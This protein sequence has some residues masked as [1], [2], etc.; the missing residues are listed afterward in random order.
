MCDRQGEAIPDQWKRKRG[1][2][3]PQES[4]GDYM[5]EATRQGFKHRGELGVCS[6]LNEAG[7]MV[8]FCSVSAHA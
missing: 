8:W 1:F 6:I 2:Q 3:L 4:G 7:L 5:E